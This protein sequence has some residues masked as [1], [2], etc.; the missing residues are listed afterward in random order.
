LAACRN[1]DQWRKFFE[2]ARGDARFLA[3]Y[4]KRVELKFEGDLAAEIVVWITVRGRD[5]YPI[6]GPEG[7]PLDKVRRPYAKP[8]E[9]TRALAYA[10]HSVTN[11]IRQ[12]KLSP[13]PLER[14]LPTPERSPSFAFS[15]INYTN[16]FY[17]N[18]GFGAQMMLELPV[19]SQFSFRVAASALYPLA[20]TLKSEPRK[21]LLY[22]YDAST[23]GVVGLD[24]CYGRYI[25]RTC[26][27]GNIG[28]VQLIGVGS[29]ITRTPAVAYLSIG[30][31]VS[32]AFPALRPGEY[33]KFQLQLDGG[34]YINVVRPQA[35]GKTIDPWLGVPS[36]VL[37]R[38]TFISGSVAVGVRYTF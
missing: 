29:S 1:T 34:Y 26:A 4:R 38:P 30:P 27:R 20:V 32:M 16:I 18:L 31:N 17:K 14:I 13:R 10:A 35:V 9:C 23:M 2:F 15:V 8:L 19:R 21:E 33:G 22:N 36:R 12:P 24:L 7:K 11:L 3:P 5:G 25:F 6:L 28:I 37:D